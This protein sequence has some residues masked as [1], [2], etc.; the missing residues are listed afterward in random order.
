[1]WDDYFQEPWNYYE[2]SVVFVTVVVTV[3]R[4]INMSSVGIYHY[5]GNGPFFNSQT[6]ADRT[7]T[8]KSLFA[9]LLVLV[10]LRGLKL[11]RIPPFTGPVTQSIM[12]VS[13]LM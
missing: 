2:W 4:I 10:Y 7:F 9:V 13:N 1:M 6:L 3:F 8:E 5:D 11:L 12:D